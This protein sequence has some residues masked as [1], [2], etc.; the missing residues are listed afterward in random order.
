MMGQ[1]DTGE[2]KTASDA[3]GQETETYLSSHAYT[4][5]ELGHAWRRGRAPAPELSSDDNLKLKNKQ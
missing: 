3:N 1:M 5:W 2:K 4:R